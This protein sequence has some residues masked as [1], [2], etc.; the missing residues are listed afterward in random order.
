M[1]IILISLLS[2]W[3]AFAQSNASDAAME[4]YV[5]DASG[6][7]MSNAQVAARNVGTNVETLAVSDG[8]GFFRFPLL[9]VGAYELRVSATGFSEFK[10]TG[11]LLSVGKLARIDVTLKVGATTESMT[12]SADASIVEQGVVAQ[13]EVTNERAV[14]SLPITS[15]NV[16][17]FH[18]LG[19]GVK[20]I[21][22]TGFGTTQFTFGGA[23]RSAWT[24][25]GLDNTARIN[26]RQIR[27][28]ISTPEAVQ[29]MQVL[30]GAYSAEFGRAA[31]GVIN[32]VSRSGTNDLH[33]GSMG[34]YRPL[35][36]TARSALA[37]A[38]TQQTWY[39]MSGNLGGA[40]KKDKLW[41]FINDEFNP[42]RTPSP[43]T[44][45]PAAAAAL[46]LPASDLVDSP[47][48]E[49]FH[50]PTAKLNF[51][52]SEKNSGFLRYNRFTND[53]PGGGGGLTTI[54]RST[55]FEDRM[56]GGAAQLATVLKPNLLNEFRFGFNRR[57]QQR[58]TYVPG[59]PN[60]AQININGVA[61]FG[62]NPL[63]GSGGIE[64]SAYLR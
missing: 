57:G 50:T 38:R 42:L 39:M 24:V 36:T 1:K 62:V 31:G 47:F 51:R 15:R 2:V 3:C 22:S 34:L 35:E 63:A 13:G 56:N 37:V 9:K 61:N 33:G 40:L 4:G 54:S 6:A 26:S 55:T 10:Q 21:P 27:L 25:D 58:L 29:E 20:G 52:L 44:I 7:R 32:V 59:E 48:G 23:N 8:Q 41:F 11:I 14:R 64:A 43:V 17:N 5:Q 12:V 53:Q 19:P 60:G 28:V 46:R 30:S 45:L 16:Y 18:L 49:T